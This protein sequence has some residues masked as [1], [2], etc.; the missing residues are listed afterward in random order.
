[1]RAEY[2]YSQI[3][4]AGQAFY[5]FV[6]THEKE[7]GGGRGVNGKWK[8][9]KEWREAVNVLRVHKI[10]MGFYF[11]IGLERALREGGLWDEHTEDFEEIVRLSEAII[12]PHQGSAEHGGGVKRVLCHDTG[13]VTGIVL[14][15][16]FVATKCRVRMIRWKAV[17]LMRRTERQ[18]GLWNSVLTA[19]AAE[20]L[21]RLE[22]EWLV[23]EKV[24]RE[25]RFRC[26]EVRFDLQERM[27]RLRYRRLEVG[28]LT[29]RPL[30]KWSGL[31]GRF[32]GEWTTVVA[33][34]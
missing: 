29:I 3:K 30:V 7:L 2:G 21:V 5:S 18:E 22:E 8:E 12:G 19:L 1:V 25:K 20:Q 23:E 26:A 6:E 15:L 4:F 27:A 17:K 32:V 13:I 16:N 28:V 14:P 9:E 24:P 11:C 10:F 34:K 33:I 31:R